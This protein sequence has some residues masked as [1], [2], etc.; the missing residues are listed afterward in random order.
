VGFDLVVQDE[1]GAGVAG[2]GLVELV[3]IAGSSVSSED[4]TRRASAILARAQRREVRPNIPASLRSE[5][6]LPAWALSRYAA[7]AASLT[8]RGSG[9]AW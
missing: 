2:L 3:V 5:S 8:A 9:I 7:T 1:I 6:G 4:G